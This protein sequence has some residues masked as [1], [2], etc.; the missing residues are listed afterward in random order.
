VRW[1][2][3]G[4]AGG[5]GGDSASAWQACGSRGDLASWRVGRLACVSRRLG[6]APSAETGAFVCVPCVRSWAWAWA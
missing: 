5:E 2:A 1:V 4:G 3:V 6:S